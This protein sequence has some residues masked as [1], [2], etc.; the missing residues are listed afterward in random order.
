MISNRLVTLLDWPTSFNQ[1]LLSTLS[2][3][4]LSR[5]LTTPHPPTH[6]PLPSS[7][8]CKESIEISEFNI[9]RPP[10]LAFK[11]SLSPPPSPLS[12]PPVMCLSSS[13]MLSDSITQILEDIEDWGVFELAV[14][15]LRVRTSSAW[16]CL[17]I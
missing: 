6:P 14:G 11:S 3:I 12:P 16:R 10:S 15:V 5:R 8:Q 13:P 1:L 9:H 4:S 17:K 7:L 2:T